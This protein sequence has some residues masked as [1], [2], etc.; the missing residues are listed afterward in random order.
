MTPAEFT[1]CSTGPL[2]TVQ[3]L[4]RPG[5]A[6]LGVP[7][8]GAADR[9]AFGLAN[10]L[11]GNRPDAACI[12]VTLGGFSARV[13][14]T[15]MVAVTGPGTRV[16]V[17]GHDVGSHSAI[18]LRN[19]QSLSVTSPR[20]GCRNYVAVRG[21]FDAAPELGSRST[22]TLSGL[23]PDPLRVKDVLPVGDLADDWPAV[24]LAPPPAPLAEPAVVLSVR[25]GPR[26]DRLVDPGQL[27]I[28]RWQ[29]NPASNRI[30][31]RLDRP[32]GST[33]PPLAHR[34][35]PELRSEGVPLG[36]VQV[37]PSGQ[38]V[39]FLPDHPVTGGYPVVA[40]LTPA[41]LSKAAQLTTGDAVRFVVA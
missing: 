34:D 12:E 27:V 41:S 37:P 19:G 8:S 9:D 4:G 39:I 7:R 38:P 1:V 5:M 14:G 21:G 17:D 18:P 35:V 16:R 36:G 11:V 2:A 25:P 40:V 26:A 28:S 33:E 24:M 30:G 32:A 23:G 10:R 15:A 20:R 22:D 6:H 3:D 13:H 31:I 29:V